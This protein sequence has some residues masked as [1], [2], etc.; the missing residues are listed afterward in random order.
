MPLRPP[1]PYFGGKPCMTKKLLPLFPPHKIY[2]EVF[3]GVGALLFAKSRSPIEVYNDRD[4]D[5]VNFMQ[6]LRDHQRFPD[7]YHRACLS[8]YSR[9]AYQFCKDHLNDDPDPVERA[10][11]FFVL[12]RFSFSGHVDSC[13]VCVS[14]SSC[15]MIQTASAYQSVLGILPRLHERF[16]SVLIENKDFRT[17]IHDFDTKDAFFY[18]DPPYLLETRHSGS[19]R[20]EMT[21]AD[22]H[23]LVEILIHLKGK[24]ILSGYQ[25]DLYDSLGWRK[26]SWLKSC[27]AAG[28]TKS[29][30][31]TGEGIIEKLQPRTECVWMNY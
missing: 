27:N 3:G 8:P 13:G 19:Y 20:Y 30:G 11:R 25:S 9:N 18:L 15:G 22:H 5:L 6:V 10:R 29:S 4:A 17:L 21:T 12:A 28:R 2:V 14:E 31:L 7:F 23:D 24:A 26:H 1:I 16:T